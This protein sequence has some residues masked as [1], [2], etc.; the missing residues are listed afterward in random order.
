[1]EELPYAGGVCPRCGYDNTKGPMGQPDF[2]LPCGTIL[3]GRYVVGRMLGQGG[4][5]ITY[6]CYDLMLARRGCVKEYFPTGSAMRAATA[7]CK[8]Y[9]G[10]TESA[11]ELRLGR[12]SLV[13]EARKAARLDDL[14]HLV[15]VWDVFYENET[16]YIVMNY[17]EGE[18]LGRYLKRTQQPLSERE[19]LRLLTPVMAD[20]GEM[21]KRGLFHRDIKPDNLMLSR[22]GEA[23]LLDLG[24]AKDVSGSR[25]G[26][27][28]NMVVSYGYSPIEQYRTNG[29]TGSWTD[30]YAL[31]A[32]IYTCVTRRFPPPPFD[33]QGGNELDMSGVSP[34]FAAALEKG[35][36]LEP[37]NRIQTMEELSTALNAALRSE[38]T[39]KRKATADQSKQK[40]KT[41]EQSTPKRK[42]KAAMIAAICAGILLSGVLSWSLFTGFGREMK[43]EEAETAQLR[44][45]P[46]A[47]VE[48][49]PA[50]TAAQAT[51]TRLS[52]DYYTCGDYEYYLTGEGA[53]ISKYN[54]NAQTLEVPAEMDGIRVA[55]I[56]NWAFQNCGSL[57]EITLPDGLLIIGERA[58]R[59][60][61]GLTSIKLPRSLTHIGD[62]AFISCDSLK[63][64]SIPIG[65][66]VIEANPFYDCK[67]L[68]AITVNTRNKNYKTIDGALYSKDGSE[69]IAYPNGRNRSH[70]SVPPGVKS[71]GDRA[72]YS[73]DS[74]TSIALSDSV[75]S[76]GNYAFMDCVNLTDITLPDSLRRIENCAFR[77]CRSLT[78]LTLQD[79]VTSIGDYAFLDCDSL[80]GVTL[81]AGLK[82]VGIGAFRGC[83]RL[84][85]VSFPASMTSV[86][87]G[88]IDACDS[89]KEIYFGG[90]QEV[91]ARLNVNAGSGVTVHFGR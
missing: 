81:P 27:S 76:I 75:T 16:A 89:L 36:A 68:N 55:G 90:T 7:S 26:K 49:A 32:T 24:A 74:L 39:T 64:M 51:F 42:N 33:R 44:T 35:L 54:G 28:S 38:T 57:T 71:I 31:S 43:N 66:S 37:Q 60:C 62:S 53:V 80:T 91:W 70:F 72:F 85:T 29:S 12:D 87:D 73:C 22:E 8:V 19:C 50:P 52:N 1:M 69:L 79:G 30:V 41:T 17:I 67:S 59:G 84:M 11:Q 45:M 34:R 46:S 6:M 14:K 3:S 20:L 5:G 61:T 58:F 82:S 88:A 65:V 4:F 2:T 9:W 56:G 78:S 77:N 21:H 86:G 48:E 10:T 25:D 47:D 40:R 18:T 63:T 23:I 13:R 83:D 15:T